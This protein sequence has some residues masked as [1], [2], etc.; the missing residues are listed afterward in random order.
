MTFAGL[1]SGIRHFEEGLQK[2][3]FAARRLINAW[4][5]SEHAAKS[6]PIAVLMM[7]A[8]AG[9]A[10]EQGWWLEAVAICVGVAGMFRV[11]E[12][13]TLTAGCIS[14]E[15]G[16]EAIVVTLL[17]TKT[18]SRAQRRQHAFIREPQAAALLLTLRAGLQPGDKVFGTLSPKVLRDR[19]RK[20]SITCG[21]QYLL[22]T[23][24]SFRRGGATI[25]FRQTN[26]FDRAATEGRWDSVRTAR[27]YVDEAVAELSSHVLTNAASLAGSA[28]KLHALFD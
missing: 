28:T 24:H 13:L 8:L 17:E 21:L 9:E 3:L 23:P 10:L 22:I 12:L 11:M 14:G 2:H 15:L 16:D 5:R 1:V 20:L 27:K 4:D 7:E 19:L 26:S 25:R 18:S 6:F